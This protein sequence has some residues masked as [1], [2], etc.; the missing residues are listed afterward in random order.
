MIKKTQQQ[1]KRLFLILTSLILFGFTINTISP[2]IQVFAE[3]NYSVIDAQQDICG[4]GGN[5]ESSDSSTSA[6]EGNVSGD[7]TTKGT[8]QYQI[9]ESLFKTLTDKYGLSGTAASGWVGNVQAESDFT[10]SIVEGENNQNYSGRGYGL[11][12]FTPGTK[13]LNSKY[14]KEGASIDDEVQAQINFVM[15]SEFKNGEYNSYIPN[16]KSWFNIDG[17]DGIE[18][19]FDAK[20]PEDSALI[21]FA[22]YER[23]DV[24]QMH[25]ERRLGAA[26][27]ANEI[28]NKNNIKADKSK[29]VAGKSSSSEVNTTGSQGATSVKNICSDDSGGTGSDKNAE[30]G[31]GKVPADATAFAYKPQD[32]PSSLKPYALDPSKVGLEYGKSP[33]WQAQSGQCVDFSNSYAALIWNKKGQAAGG[34]GIATASGWASIFGSKLKDK[35]KTGAVFSSS[36]DPIYGHTGIVSHVFENGDILVIEQNCI[37][38]SGIWGIGQVNTWNY[39]VATKEYMKSKNYVF[40]YPDKGDAKVK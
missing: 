35:P 30:D 5:K 20:S 24:A 17:V 29:W 19:I 33:N 36:E 22:V 12:Q 9:A 10:P 16:A 39:R 34:N 32:L 2:T 13:F 37:G 40:A 14:H 8:K 1:S 15:D 18:D 28:F 11:F 26:K 31:T 23:G 6:V 7:W 3:S 27:K 25:R 21:F 38:Y 4:V